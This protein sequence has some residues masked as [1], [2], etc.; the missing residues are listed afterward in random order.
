VGEHTREILG[1]LGYGAGD[2]ERLNASGVV[3][4][5]GA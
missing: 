1:E 2:I 3:G 5:Y 4:C